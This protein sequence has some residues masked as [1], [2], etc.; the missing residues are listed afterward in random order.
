MEKI[1]AEELKELRHKMQIKSL[2][3]E[4]EME[5]DE[6]KRKRNSEEQRLMRLHTE[7]LVALKSQH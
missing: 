3:N 1:R 6:L 5:E 2:K 4:A 7:Y